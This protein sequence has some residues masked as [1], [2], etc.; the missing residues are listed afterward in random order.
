MAKQSLVVSAIVMCFICAL[1][2]NAQNPGDVCDPDRSPGYVARVISLSGTVRAFDESGRQLQIASGTL[3]TQ[4]IKLETAMG[5]SVEF[6]FEDGT[7]DR[8]SRLQVGSGTQVVLTGG[9]YCDDLRPM[10]ERGVWTASEIGI[11]LQSGSLRIDLAEGVPSLF[12]LVVNTPNSQAQM[13][14]RTQDRMAAE[15]QVLGFEGRQLVPIL[16][17]P[18][19]REHVS[20]LLM[21]KPLDNLSRSE[22]DG[23]LSHAVILA[24]NLGLM[25]D[26]QLAFLDNPQIKPVID[27]MTAGRKLEELGN[28]ERNMVLQLACGMAIEAGVVN[29]ETLKVYNHPDELTRISVL[30]GMM[31]VHNKHRGWK[32]NEVVDIGSGKFTEVRGYDLPLP[33]E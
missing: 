24:V 19:I 26:R 13:V 32:L 4:G 28:D 2:V 11:N 15:V 20:L 12:K 8:K 21:G 9:L 18:K 1:H 23:V 27:M 14:R 25:D 16:E 17:H 10:V 3:I 29:P 7:Q 22:K 33:A 5:A 30:A 31:S 6:A